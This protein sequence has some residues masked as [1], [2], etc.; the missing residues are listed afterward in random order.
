MK[1][2]AFSDAGCTTGFGNV[3]D[4]LYS[5]WV[6]AGHSVDVLAVN[7]LGDP[8]PSEY[9]LWPARSPDV[10][11][12]SR[13]REVL[14]RVNPDV[15]FIM[16]DLPIIGNMLFRNR[17]DMPSMLFNYPIMTYSPIDCKGLP[18]SWV[19]PIKQVE[20]ATVQSLWGQR[21]L[22]EEYDLDVKVHWH[23]YDKE[24]FYPITKDRPQQI[25]THYEGHASSKVL[26]NKQQAKEAMKYGGKFIVL[27][28]NRNSQRKNLGE[29]I[30]VFS[31]FAKDKADVL[32]YLHAQVV[33]NG[34]NLAEYISR[35]GIEDKVAVTPDVN[36]FVGHTPDALNVFYNMA[37][38]FLTTSFSEGFGLSSLEAE[39][40]GLPVI[41]TDFSSFGEV[42]GDAGILTPVD[43]YYLTGTGVDMALPDL[44]SMLDALN[45]LYYH[46]GKRAF[47]G[48][49]G[50][51]H[52]KQFDWDV[53]ALD[54]L[55]DL[56]EAI[57]R[58]KFRANSRGLVL[59]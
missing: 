26:K 56:N 51:N 24:K 30:R 45:D 54:M 2:L 40:T 44:N 41:A 21:V 15:V 39:A 53:I 12:M 49:N 55:E 48:Q 4:A 57:A 42:V 10:Y 8:W 11:G 9:K 35:F 50:I 14:Q 59:K 6:A 37:D 36:T 52:A 17:L 34:I 29:T 33:D 43:R 46:P 7:Y 19:E 58:H 38:V 20:V 18:P 3:A 27:N 32:L 16:N 13:V 1:I 23:G 5:R 22:K 28:I 31:E 47:L 25:V